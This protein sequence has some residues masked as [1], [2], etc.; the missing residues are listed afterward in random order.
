MLYVTANYKLAAIAFVYSMA[1]IGITR[2]CEYWISLFALPRID[3][4]NSRHPIVLLAQTSRFITISNFMI[5][6]PFPI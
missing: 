2:N 6:E 4:T 1:E 5:E 3:T